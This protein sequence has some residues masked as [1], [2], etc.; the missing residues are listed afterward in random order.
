MPNHSIHITTGGSVLYN[1]SSDI[2]GFQF[3][4][5]G[6]P[7]RSASGGEA[8]AQSFSISAN[9]TTVLGISLSGATFS[10]CGTL[11]ELSLDGEP[12][13][14]S[15]VIISDPAGE[16]SPFE[17]FDGRASGYNGSP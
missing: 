9:A 16:A 10:D 2:A 6:A 7:V 1:S 15:G 17:Y 5:G 12:T 8:E 4:V 3:D 13:G 14:L 11:V